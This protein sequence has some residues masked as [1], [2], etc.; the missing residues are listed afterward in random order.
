MVVTS[1]M[2]HFKVMSSPQWCHGSHMTSSVM[3][4]SDTPWGLSYR[5]RS[6]D[7]DTCI[8]PLTRTHLGDRSFS[9]AGPRL[10]NSLPAELRQPDVEIGQFRRLLWAVLWRKAT[11]LFIGA[12]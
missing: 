6:A 5:L 7:V 11:F 4:L 1:E 8:V 9:V 10:W 12:L 3:W 2:K